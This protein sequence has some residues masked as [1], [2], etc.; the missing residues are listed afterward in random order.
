MQACRKDTLL[1]PMFR[2]VCAGLIG[3][4][5]GMRSTREPPATIPER[6]RAGAVVAT[7]RYGVFRTKQ[8]LRPAHGKLNRRVDGAGLDPQHKLPPPAFVEALVV[9][10]C[11]GR[12]LAVPLSQ[13]AAIEVND[14]TT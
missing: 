5:K 1:R 2:R 9:I 3:V 8:V 6:L 11:Q 4:C 12:N 10:R 7:R 14:S 13:L